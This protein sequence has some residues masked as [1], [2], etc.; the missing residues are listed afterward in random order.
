VRAGPLLI[1]RE[2]I[3]TGV[4]RS[5]HAEAAHE[6]AIK[7]AETDATKRALVTFGTPFG[8]VLYDKDQGQ[9]TKPAEKPPLHQHQPPKTNARSSKWVLTIGNGCDKQF[10]TSE[11]FVEATLKVVDGLKT[12]A[13]VYAF[14]AANLGGFAELNW[15]TNGTDGGPMQR[16]VQAL[17]AKLRVLAGTADE[18]SPSQRP[19][20][21]RRMAHWRSRKSDGFE[22]R[23]LGICG[24]SCL[25]RMRSTARTGSPRPLRITPSHANEG[26]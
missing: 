22:T 16:I 12:T 1:V 9:V 21:A 26:L 17:Q 8:L 3:G 6:I 24:P 11:A 10:A 2:G 13:A 20:K 5:N 19:V 25:S 23:P 18:K 4:G 14:W 15:Q 7:A